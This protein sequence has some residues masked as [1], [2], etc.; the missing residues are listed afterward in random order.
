[1]SMLNI[2]WAFIHKEKY[3]CFF[4]ATILFV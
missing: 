1:M 4:I 2:E 3:E